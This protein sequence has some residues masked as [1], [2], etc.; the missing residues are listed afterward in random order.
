MSDNSATAIEGDFGYIILGAAS[1][2]WM[3]ADRL[4]ADGSTSVLLI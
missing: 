4:S 3:L 2:G 1:A